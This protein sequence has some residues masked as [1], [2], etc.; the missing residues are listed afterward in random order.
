MAKYTGG[1]HCG[2]I[3]YDVEGEIDQVLDC[4]CS[5]CSRRGGLLWFVPA[6]AFTLK[7][8]ESNYGTYRFNTMK[9]AHHFCKSCGIAPFTEGSAPDGT[10]VVCI[11]AR[12]LDGVDV[13]SLKVV[14]YDGRSR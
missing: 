10:P 5:L 3:A 7:T 8:P 1:C 4:N 13:A 12:C 14:P 9:L 6:S 11:N 2:A